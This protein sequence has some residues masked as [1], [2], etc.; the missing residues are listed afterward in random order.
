MQTTHKF[1]FKGPAVTLGRF[2]DVKEGDVLTLTPHEAGHISED[3]RFEPYDEKKHG[4]K[5]EAKPIELPKGFDKM[6]AAEKA[7]T[8]KELGLPENFCKLNEE[9][10][11][12]AIAA[13]SKLQNTEAD[14]KDIVE[15]RNHEAEIEVIRQM[16]I[17]ELR[18]L[19]KKLRGEGKTVDCPEGANSKVLRKAIM[20]TLFGAN[21]G[22]AE[23]GDDKE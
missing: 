8:L 19:V 16:K 10:Q 15:Q 13:A 14:R 22:G 2:G 11:A 21:A 18:E 4:K 7:K 1:Y 6:S 3:D 9:H 12:E 23:E 5:S 20:N 17:E